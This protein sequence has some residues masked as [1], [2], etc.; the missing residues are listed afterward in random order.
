MTLNNINKYSLLIGLI[1]SILLSSCATQENVT[2]IKDKEISPKDKVQ[3]QEPKV[4]TDGKYYKDD[5]PPE[6]DEVDWREVANAVPSYNAIPKQFNRPYE[7]FG[8][9]YVPFTD[10]TRYVKRGEASWYGRRY[11]GRKTSTGETYNMYEMTAAHPILPIPSYVRVTR[12]DDGRSIIVRVN[13]RG[14]FLQERIIDLSY[15]AARKLGVVADGTAEVI[16]EALL[17]N[18]NDNFIP[19][20]TEAAIQ[21]AKVI[22]TENISSNA[23]NYLQ[24]G[25]FSSIDNA[26]NFAA[27]LIL[28]ST[29]S[30]ITVSVIDTDDKLFRVIIGPYTSKNQAEEDLNRLH[31]VGMEALLKVL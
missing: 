29:L 15:V 17:P 13:D 22:N 8:V 2:L 21:K 7:V 27:S 16:V 9:R 28:P 26:K 20:S 25:A 3:V 5:G 11:H 4:T 24:V 23:N 10:Y 12:I 6:V 1:G 31:V 30:I 18:T 14:P 19:V